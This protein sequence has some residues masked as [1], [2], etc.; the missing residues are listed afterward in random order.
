MATAFRLVFQGS[1]EVPKNN[2]TASGLG[3]LIF[4]PLTTTLSYD[5]TI[6][7][8]DFGVPFDSGTPQTVGT[9]DDVTGMH[10]H[11]AARGTNGGIVLNLLPTSEDGD[12]VGVI[13]P[14][15]STT[16]SGAWDPTDA[17]ATSINVF[18][19][20]LANAKIGKDVNLYFNVHTNNFIGGE[21]RAQFVAIANEQSNTVNGTEGNDSLPGLGGNDT[22]FGKGGND[23]LQGGEENDTLNGGQGDD[24]LLGD[25]GND[26]AS[27]QNDGAVNVSLLL[28]GSQNT[29]G[30]GNDELVSIE[31]LTG[32]AAGGDNLIGDGNANV[33]KGLRRQRYAAWRRRPRHSAGRPGQRLHDRWRRR[34]HLR[35]QFQDRE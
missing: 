2:S 15:G 7:G 13:N 30:A 35:L 8:I 6:L 27:Y 12:R 14:D 1:Q 31:N 18:A 22:I 5:Y 33:L 32:S 21:I 24:Q 29:G 4:D 3:T 17:S 9:G 28:V 20:A 10:I 16:I 19:A 25:N 34:R 26:T 11:N 23:E